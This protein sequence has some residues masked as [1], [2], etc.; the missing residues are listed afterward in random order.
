MYT[1]E[2][3]KV[4]TLMFPCVMSVFLKNEIEYAD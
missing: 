1:L 3:L 2:Q 4:Y